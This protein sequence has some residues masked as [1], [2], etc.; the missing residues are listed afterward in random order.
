MPP[1]RARPAWNVRPTSRQG[2]VAR[3]V[4]EELADRIAPVVGAFAIPPAVA[5]GTG[6][7]GVVLLSVGCTGSLLSTGQHI[8]TA[9]HCVDSNGDGRPDVTSVTVRFDLP[10]GPISM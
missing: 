6:F 9:A 2:R 8:L 1:P 3:L 5:P 10:G 4:L 7:D